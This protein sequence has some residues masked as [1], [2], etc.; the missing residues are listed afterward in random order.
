G[1]RPQYVTGTST[2]GQDVLYIAETA[3][4]HLADLTANTAVNKYISIAAGVKNI[5]DVSNVN[6]TA[7]SSGSIHNA[8]GAVAISYG[9]S[10]FIGLNLQWNRKQK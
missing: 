9:R 1:T 4:Y 3:G 10:Y 5:F 8:G 2:S 6:N 7:A